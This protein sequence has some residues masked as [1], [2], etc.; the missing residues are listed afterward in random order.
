[1]S[2]V[3]SLSER[4]RAGSPAF[5]AWCGI[6][7]PS[8][9]GILAREPFDAVTLDMQHGVIDFAAV[10]RAIPLIA[11]VGKPALVRIPVGEFAT[12]SRL[13]DAG[14]SG[15]IAPMVNTVEDAQRF[16]AFMKYPPL[17][18]RSWG[19]HTAVALSGLTPDAYFA[20]ANGF[21]TALAMVETRE[22]LGIIDDILSV[23][24]IDGVFI[25]PSD[26][27]IAL[28]KGARND[29][30]G[31]EVE[32]ALDHAVKRAKAAGKLIAVYAATGERA[33][34]FARLGFNLIAIGS[35]TGFL[36]AGAQTALAAARA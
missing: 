12:A 3:S 14:A 26:L 18:E 24:S 28:S 6:S 36:R 30:A 5:S 2:S 1:M 11:A 34:A 22:A 21:T 29:P 15:V 32:Q 4:L 25:G 35:D 7:E 10:A 9:G 31:A 17:G 16:G 20:Q 19:P 27:S 33:A 8:V 23:S 13:C